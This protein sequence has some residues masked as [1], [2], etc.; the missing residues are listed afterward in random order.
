MRDILNVLKKRNHQKIHQSPVT[1][2]ER[3]I[4][5]YHEAYPDIHIT[6]IRRSGYNMFIS[7]GGM[8]KYHC[9]IANQVHSNNRIYFRVYKHRYIEQLCYNDTCKTKTSKRIPIKRDL[10]VKLGNMRKE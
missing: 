5:T 2:L 10:K 3:C 6:S 4:R 9:G 8:G 7:V 1:D